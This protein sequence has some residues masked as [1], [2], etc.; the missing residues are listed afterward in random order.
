M[1]EQNITAGLLVKLMSEISDERWCAGWLRNLGT[2]CGMRLWPGERIFAAR[3]IE[4][5]LEKD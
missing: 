1:N 4:R 2:C 3:K 5:A